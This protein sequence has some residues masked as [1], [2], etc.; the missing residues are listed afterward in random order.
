MR[1]ISK[2]SQSFLFLSGI[3]IGAI[4]LFMYDQMGPNSIAGNITV[5][6][7]GILFVLGI[8]GW[9]LFGL[10]LTITG[11]LG[12]TD[13]GISNPL[14]FIGCILC[15]LIGI[16]LVVK[17]VIFFKN[18]KARINLL[19]QCIKTVD[20]CPSCFQSIPELKDF[21]NGTDLEI[22]ERIYELSHRKGNDFDWMYQRV[23]NNQDSSK[24]TKNPS[25]MTKLCPNCF[26][27]F[28]MGIDNY[29]KQYV[30]FDS[31]SPNMTECPFC[32]EMIDKNA[33]K[34]PC[35]AE[36]LS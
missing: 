30:Q 13:S 19:R 7:G 27:K 8:G 26:A 35:C 9:G 34:C 29:L 2:S 31:K 6:I 1:E 33:N 12:F 10:L 3:I 36:N 32:S 4:S 24:S 14:D 11:I 5:A 23:I 18:K 28:N 21:H 16:F 22:F 15:L 20:F 17:S 25:I